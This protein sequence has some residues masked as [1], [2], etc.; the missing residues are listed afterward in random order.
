MHFQSVPGHPRQ[1]HLGEL[2]NQESLSPL[3][4][5]GWMV[6]KDGCNKSSHPSAPFAK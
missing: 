1:Y 3:N 5:L 2:D 4:Q 6:C